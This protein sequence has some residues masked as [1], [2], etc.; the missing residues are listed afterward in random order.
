[1][2][3]TDHLNDLSCS[4]TGVTPL[5]LYCYQLRASDLW[6]LTNVGRKKLNDKLA[7][8]F[9]LLPAAHNWEE[10]LDTTTL[11]VTQKMKIKNNINQGISN[12]ILAILQSIMKP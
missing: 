11:S 9:G 4:P 1:M 12:I 5:H 6:K 10:W 3:M 8:Y 2:T 7:G